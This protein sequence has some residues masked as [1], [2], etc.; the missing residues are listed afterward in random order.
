LD[1]LK[2]WEASCQTETSQMRFTLP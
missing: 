1:E 2:V